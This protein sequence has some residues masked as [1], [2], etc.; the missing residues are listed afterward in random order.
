MR[1]SFYYCRMFGRMSLPAASILSPNSRALRNSDD[2]LS[3]STI[4]P[5][6]PG[7]CCPRMHTDDLRLAPLLSRFLLRQFLAEFLPWLLSRPPP[8]HRGG[9]CHR[10]GRRGR[11]HIRNLELALVLGGLAAFVLVEAALDVA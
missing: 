4:A 2:G 5:S 1:L 10:R 11:R 3:V 8:D 6:T 9:R 7:R